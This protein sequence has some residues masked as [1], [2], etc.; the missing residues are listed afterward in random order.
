MDSFKKRIETFKE[1]VPNR[2]KADFRSLLKDL[3]RFSHDLGYRSG[4][5]EMLDCPEE[6][7]KHG[8][9]KSMGLIEY[10]S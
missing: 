5:V 10:D 9:I 3:V 8:V 7:T 1:C 2:Y 6:L 4:T